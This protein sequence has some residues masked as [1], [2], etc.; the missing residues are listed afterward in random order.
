MMIS[1]VQSSLDRRISDLSLALLHVA[2]VFSAFLC[3]VSAQEMDEPTERSDRQ[4]PTD[5]TPQQTPLPHGMLLSQPSSQSRPELKYM[6]LFVSRAVESNLSATGLLDDQL[7]GRLYGD[8]GSTTLDEGR[9][10][11][12]QRYLSF[13]DYQPL[14]VNHRARLKAGFE[15]DFT[16]GDSANSV[17]SN[18]GGAINGDQV[19]LQTKRLLVELDLSKNL[20]LVVGLQPLSD[21]AFNP[22]TAN[23]HDLLSGGGRLL[24]WGTDASGLS[25]FGRWGDHRAR[26]SLFHLNLNE[27]AESDDIF[28]SMVDAEFKVTFDSSFGVHLW[29]L[30]DQSGAR[31]GGVDSSISKYTGTTFLELGPDLADAEL[32]WGGLDYSYN[33][34]RRGGRLSLDLAAFFSAGWFSIKQGD[35]RDGEEDARCPKDQNGEVPTFNDQE[36]DVLGL[37]LDGQLA[38]RWGR[39]DWDLIALTAIYATGDNSPLDR[40]LSSPITGNSFGTPGA[41]FAHHRALLLFPDPRSVNR[42]VGV[43]YDPGNLGY[44]LQAFTLSGSGDLIAELINLKF[45]FAFATTAATPVDSASRIIGAEINTEL[46]YRVAPFLW[47]G[48]HGA[49]ARL[50]RFLESASRVPTSPIPESNQP[51]TLAMS[52][53]WLQL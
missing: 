13:F 48:V 31:A 22:T 41:L 42:H 14:S 8:N 16:Y 46:S 35:C 45:G 12:E 47:L 9:T 6:G 40:T 39:G 36:A 29:H 50:G 25:L 26:A 18:T 15:V 4:S 21:S 20:Q 24:F 17:G 51:W 3:P 49:T 28:L 5:G 33:R 11:V 19:N 37:L 32:F 38:Y 1:C 30:T 44:G 7:V 43:V 23:P 34:G 2:T 53:T 27:A 10:Y 52:L